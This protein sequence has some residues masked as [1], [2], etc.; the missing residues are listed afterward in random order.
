MV[1]PI[2]SGWERLCQDANCQKEIVFR[3]S[4]SEVHENYLLSYLLIL[5]QVLNKCSETL[6]HVVEDNFML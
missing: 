1:E 6:K 5:S 3:Q 2:L 4:W